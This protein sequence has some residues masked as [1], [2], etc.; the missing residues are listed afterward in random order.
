MNVTRELEIHECP[1]C[2]ILHGV[3]ASFWRARRAD[4]ATFYCPNGHGISFRDTENDRIRRERDRLKQEQAQLLDSI[5]RREAQRDVALAQAAARK[6]VITKMKKRA[7]NG[8][9]PCCT[10]SF[11]DLRR[12]MATKHPAFMAEEIDVVVRRVDETQ[13]D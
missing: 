2:F 10:R 8:V 7:A 12:H 4:G 5:K 13:G 1:S 3:P 11:A 6:G 9:C